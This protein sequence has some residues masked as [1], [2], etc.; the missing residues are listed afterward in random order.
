LVWDEATDVSFAQG[1]FNKLYAVIC[2]KGRF[3]VRVTLPVAPR[4]KT[5]SE[6]ATLSFVRE[7]TAVPVPQVLEYAVNPA[8]SSGFE[9]IMMERVVGRPLRERWHEISWLNQETAPGPASS[10]HDYPAQPPITTIHREYL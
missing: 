4:V 10:Q 1:A 3:I 7:Q 6:V 5:V 9:W 8:N 2:S